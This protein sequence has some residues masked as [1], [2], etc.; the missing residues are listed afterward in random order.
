MVISGQTGPNLLE[1]IFL[2][3]PGDGLG[4]IAQGV[5]APDLTAVI[6]PQVPPVD[7][8]ATATGI[9]GV[10]PGQTGPNDQIYIDLPGSGSGLGIVGFTNPT[11]DLTAVLFGDELPGLLLASIFGASATLPVFSGEYPITASIIPSNSG[12]ASL[13]GVFYRAAYSGTPLDLDAFIM[14]VSSGEDGLPGY[15]RAFQTGS[16]TLSGFIEPIPPVPLYA[17]IAPQSILTITGTISGIEPV[18]LGATISGK[19]YTPITASIQ[20]FDNLDVMATITGMSV[21]GLPATISG[22]V[23]DESS[24]HSEINTDELYRLF[25]SIS[26]LVNASG[27]IDAS[28]DPVLPVDIGA[29]YIPIP[30]VPISATVTGLLP[31]GTIEATITGQLS[32]EHLAASITSTGGFADLGH[33]NPHGVFIRGTTPSQ[34]ELDASIDGAE[35]LD[36]GATINIDPQQLLTAAVTASGPYGSTSLLGNINGVTASD[37]TASLTALDP[38]K[39]I[40]S[41]TS[42]L[43]VTLNATIYPDIFYIDALIPINTFAV[44]DLKA[45]INSTE[46]AFRTDVSSIG[47][48]INPIYKGDLEAYI[49]G[50]NQS[51]RAVD[52]LPIDLN[53]QHLIKDY[54]A[55]NLEPPAIAT[56]YLPLIIVNSPFGD[57]SATIFGIGESAD[58]TASVRGLTYGSFITSDPSTGVWVNPKTGERKIIRFLFT[59]TGK[60]YYYSEVANKTFPEYIKDTIKVIVETYDPIVVD[61]AIGT[62]SLAQKK[63]VRRCIVSDLTPFSTWDEAVKYGIRCAAGMFTDLT[64]YIVALNTKLDLRASYAPINDDEFSDLPGKIVCVTNQPIIDASINPVGGFADIS[65]YTRGFTPGHTLPPT[66]ISGELLETLGTVAVTYSGEDPQ[67]IL[68]DMLKS[69]S[70][71]IPSVTP[72]LEANIIGIDELTISATITGSP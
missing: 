35:I 46:C 61:P 29:G 10:F 11:P 33:S 14:P 9:L 58:L 16:G 47:A 34:L 2:D 36:L 30:P 54:F 18:D 40:A 52:L 59:L 67:I 68:Q 5:L 4:I 22:F 13:S 31:P 8:G 3:L 44:N 28:Y 27:S 62:T 23:S 72:D 19:G 7:L 51:V 39:L 38:P 6:T 69:G 49:I 56:D 26:G 71:V 42:V 63:N 20:G 17:T 1:D 21:E 37:L 45:V 41:Y 60:T 32:P 53:R 12:D 50:A 70:L 55:L 24:L 43:G 25:C 64:A 15:Y 66:V 65:L 57:L 48:Y